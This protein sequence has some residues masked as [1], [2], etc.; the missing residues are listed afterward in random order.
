VFRALIAGATDPPRP[1]GVFM[2]QADGLIT[3]ITTVRDVIQGIGTVS[4]LRDPVIA[5]DGSVV[6]SMVIAGVGPGLF[7]ARDG[8]L[9]PLAVLGD[10]TDADAG[11]S[12]FRFGSAAVT[13]SAEGAAFLGERDAIFGTDSAGGVTALAYTGRPSRLGG[14]MASLGP[15]VVDTSGRVFFG[16]ELQRALFNEVLLVAE[17]DD[18]DTFISPDRRLLGGGGIAEFFPTNVDALARPNSAPTGVVFTAALQGAK[19]SEAV[20][21]ARSRNRTRALLKVGQRASGQ[22]ITGLGTPA[23]GGR[24]SA[25]ALLAEVGRESRRAV[26]MTG[27]GVSAVAIEGG[28]TRSRAGGRFGELGAPA[29]GP[30]GALFRATIEGTSQ[31]GLFVARGRKTGLI[32]GSGDLTTTGARL[33]SFTDPIA[34]GD[35]VWFLARL[36]GTVAPAG[37]YRA[38]VTAIPGKSDAPLPIEPILIPGDPAPTSVGGVIVRLDGLR[39]GPG[40]TISAIADI[41]GGTTSSAILEFGP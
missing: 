12:R 4:R 7:I 10:A 19:A 5:D 38:I 24:R 20:F 37:L 27:G 40:G 28:T 16:V 11:D 39:V 17:G 14:I 29:L 34:R 2:V 6:V 9:V 25:V 41:G 36:A 32:A 18:L 1:S 31:E 23:V 35:E 8:D 21:L 13:T 15:P 3:R 33:R 26:V 22:R 30:H